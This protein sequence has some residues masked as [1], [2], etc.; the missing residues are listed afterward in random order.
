MTTQHPKNVFPVASKIDYKKLKN[1][2]YSDREKWKA[3]R[4]GS[5]DQ[6]VTVGK[7]P[8]NA[9]ILA[10]YCRDRVPRSCDHTLLGAHGTPSTHPSNKRRM[11]NVYLDRNTNNYKTHER[12]GYAIDNSQSSY[13]TSNQFDRRGSSLDNSPYNGHDGMNDYTMKGRGIDVRL[14]MEGRGIQGVT[15]APRLPR[16]CALAESFLSTGDSLT[17]ELRLADSTALKYVKLTNTYVTVWLLYFFLGNG[18]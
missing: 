7:P 1:S 14:S 15:T 11:D 13:G 9:T 6:P 8:G 18:S 16:P 12:H 5:L 4:T 2:C 17:L 10:R 3:V